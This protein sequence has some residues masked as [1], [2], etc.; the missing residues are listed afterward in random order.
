MASTTEIPIIEAADENRVVIEYNH[1]QY[2][3]ESTLV[4]DAG[5]F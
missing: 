4:Q 2:I 5:F 1:F 3:L